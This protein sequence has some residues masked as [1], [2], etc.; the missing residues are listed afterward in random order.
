M[1]PRRLGDLTPHER[2]RAIAG[3]LT[4]CAVSFV[5]IFLLYFALPLSD[6]TVDAGAVLTL[7]GGAILF[8]AVLWWQFRR[9][10]RADLPQLKAFEAIIV[11]VPMFVV[12][13][14][15]TY[16]V[17]SHLNHASF[18]EKLYHTDSLYFTIVTLGTVG[19]GDIAPKSHVARLLV[20]SQVLLDLA[21]IALLVRAVVEVSRRRLSG[22]E[23]PADSEPG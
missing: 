18:S 3:S 22:T 6:R 5:A 7:I 9:I 21:L 10:A 13:Y 17:M 14:A 12:V 19:Y 8:G 15:A 16:V 2:R 11:A 20:S 23:P 1:S 4:R